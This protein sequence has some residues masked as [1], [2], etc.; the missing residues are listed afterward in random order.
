MSKGNKMLVVDRIRSYSVKV[1]LGDDIVGSGILVKSKDNKPYLF[2]ARHLFKERS[3]DTFKQVKEFHI[4]QKTNELFITRESFEKKIAIDEMMFFRD[5]LDLIVFSL[6]EEPPIEHL[7]IIKVLKNEHRTQNY[8]FY[9][10]PEGAKSDD[11]VHTG[12]FES[13][14]YI[15]SNEEESHI[16]RLSAKKNIGGDDVSGYSGSGVFVESKEKIQVG[17]ELIEHSIVYLVGILIRAKE[18]L[19]Y[20]EAIDLSNIIDDINRKANIEILTIEDIFDTK[21]TKNIKT[22]IL[23]RNREDTF[24]QRFET[25]DNEENKNILKEFLDNSENEL[26]EMTK[27]LA[28]F[29]LLGGMTYK[30]MGD[31]E[32]SKKYFKLA[33]KFNP[34]Y[35]RYEKNY[36]DKSDDEENED[37]INH[38]HKGL[39]AFHNH[40]YEE[41]KNAFL[42]HYNNENIEKLEKIELLKYLS[43]IYIKEQ[44]YMEAQMYAIEALDE[45]SKDNYLEK[46]ELYYE[47]FQI[48]EKGKLGCSLKWINQGLEYLRENQDENVLVIKRKLEVEKAKLTKDDYIKT[49]SPTLIEL[50]QRYPEEY[51]DDFIKEYLDS[52]KSESSNYSTISGKVN[53]L[54]NYLDGIQNKTDKDKETK[55]INPNNPLK[56]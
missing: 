47:L 53:E 34:T 8:H 13:A 48:C 26:T 31:D 33:T 18:G 40:E 10:Y 45:Y 24:I 30:D 25:L 39:I 52:R 6:K 54:K 22:K 3:D 56:D 29:Y 5:D 20:Y 7:P 42:E 9:G 35:K 37:S 23:K 16:F 41:A 15:Q 4:R 49:M 28:D 43:K 2:T 44:N 55:K 38:Y 12:H 1:E 27:K 11:E 17:G 21:F 36:E 14:Q 51:I 19:S 50:V 32:A 46:A